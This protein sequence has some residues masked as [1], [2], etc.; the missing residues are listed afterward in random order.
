MIFSLVGLISA[1][2]IFI[3]YGRVLNYLISVTRTFLHNCISLFWSSSTAHSIF[4]LILF[5]QRWLL[6]TIWLAVVSQTILVAIET[7]YQKGA[8]WNWKISLHHLVF[9]GSRLR[10]NYWIFLLGA[11]F[12][13]QEWVLHNRKNALAHIPQ[14]KNFRSITSSQ[15]QPLPQT[16]FSFWPPCPSSFRFIESLWPQ[17]SFFL[18]WDSQHRLWSHSNYWK[19]AYPH[20]LFQHQSV[21]RRHQDYYS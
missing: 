8:G 19:P 14:V 6:V 4:H 5:F 1:F 2:Q 10:R 21:C 12:Y 7:L 15:N 18:L 16:Y 20:K 3:W 9:P 13:C 11:L 17:P